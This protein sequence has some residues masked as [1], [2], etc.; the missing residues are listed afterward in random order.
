MGILKA[1]ETILG[2][3]DEQM[4][5]AAIDIFSYVV[6]FSPPMVREFIVEEGQKQDDVRLMNISTLILTII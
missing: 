5:A 6:E 2:L 1:L 4:K 3:D